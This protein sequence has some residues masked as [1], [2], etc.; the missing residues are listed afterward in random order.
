MY[1][2]SLESG[3]Q[4]ISKLRRQIDSLAAIYRR[5]GWL[6][7]GDRVYQC[8]LLMLEVSDA[9][10]ISYVPSYQC[11]E[12]LCPRCARSRSLRIASNAADVASFLRQ[13]GEYRTP[14]HVVLTVRNVCA[15]DLSAMI[16]TMIQSCRWLLHRRSIWRSVAGWGRSIEVTYN[17]ESNTFHPHVHLLVIPTDVPDPDTIGCSSWWS[18]QWSAA[19]SACGHDIDYVPVCR[20]DAA[21]SD[22]VLPEVSKYI[23]K[24]SRLFALPYETRYA[25][26]VTIDQ[27]TRGRKL[28]SYGGIWAEARRQLRQRDDIDA[29]DDFVRARS[30][31]S[32]I[33]RWSGLEYRPVASETGRSS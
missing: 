1:Y 11:G 28:V 15:D 19:L 32:T 2:T 24:L 9:M 33:L 27:A 4:A 3:R 8:G 10:G 16:D 25:C 23:T 7:R 6:R 12:R 21:Y 22:G 18:S 14:Y 30:C 20:S 13:T 17:A 31:T 26:I 5:A 29:S